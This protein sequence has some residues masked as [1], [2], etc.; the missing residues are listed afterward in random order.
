MTRRWRIAAALAGGLILLA[1]SAWGVDFRQVRDHVAAADPKWLLAGAALYLVSYFVRSLRW[2]LVLNPVERVTVTESYAMLM[3]GYFLNYVIPVRAGEVA[4]SFF[5]KRLKGTP[6][7]TSLP[8]VFVDKLLEFV[9]I[10]LV[11]LMVPML[12]IRL[13]RP[14]AALIT[15]LLIIFLAALGL[16]AVAFWKREATTKFLCRMLSWLPL[17]VY[18]RLSRWVSLFVS[19]MG[20]AR[21]NLRALPSLMGLTIL[22]VL[23]DAAYFSMMFRAFSV[24]VGFAHVVFGYTLLT[25]SYILPTPPAQIGYNEL[26]VGLIFAGGLTGANVD[27]GS[28]LAVVIV[29]H[30]ITGALIAIVGLAAFWTMGIRVSDS[31]RGVNSERELAQ[32]ERE[33]GAPSEAGDVKP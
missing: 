24:D 3:A 6:I 13:E 15:A 32:I 33:A 8:T 10:V 18:D 20:V 28:V 26:V 23:L 16:L 5:L 2:R 9:S 29:A 14:I 7:A 22:A 12:S 17:R 4:K 19:G 21:E 1:L 31:F 11:V 25:L 27:R 30:A